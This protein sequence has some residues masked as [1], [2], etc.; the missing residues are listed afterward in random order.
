[1]VSSGICAQQQ[2]SRLVVTGVTAAWSCSFPSPAAG[3][4]NLPAPTHSHT[5]KE[6]KVEVVNAQP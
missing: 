6:L 2:L 4:G 3:D 5:Q 1:M